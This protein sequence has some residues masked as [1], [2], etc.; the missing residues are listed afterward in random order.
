[1]VITYLR[2]VSSVRSV[3]S[4]GHDG[5]AA[6][7]PSIYAAQLVQLAERWNVARTAL[8]EGTGLVESQ[9]EDPQVRVSPAAMWSLLQRALALTNEPALGFYLGLQLKLSSHGSVGFAAMTAATL[10]DA[11]LVAERY[12]T[13]RAP[14]LTLHL[15]VE[16]EHATLTL[17]DSFP[18]VALRTFVTEALFTALVQMAHSL[19]GRSVGGLFELAYAEPAYF[20]G[21]SH[22]WGGPARFDRNESRLLFPKGLLDEP[23]RMADAV[24]AR[25][26]VAECER[27]LATLHQTSSLLA[28]VR[29]QLGEDPRG[30]PSLTELAHK[31]HVSPRTLKRRLAEQHTSYQRLL[32]ELRRDR[33]LKLLEVKSHTIEEIAVR[34]GYSDAANFNRAFRRWLGVSPS[35]WR[36]QHVLGLRTTRDSEHQ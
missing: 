31:R 18:D 7:I 16:D 12:L 5:S 32:D 25:Q 20:P 2:S 6:S 10:R 3:S 1:M 36:A 15:T 33:A 24:A 23:L 35:R 9:L 28:S 30:F 11:L 13:L 21:F 26:A 27:E 14:F 29:S 4:E 34:L 17:G 8:L 22:L 19:L